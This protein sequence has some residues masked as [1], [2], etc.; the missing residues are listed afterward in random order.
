MSSE[1]RQ[2][3]PTLHRSSPNPLGYAT[4]DPRYIE[5]VADDALA[6]RHSDATREKCAT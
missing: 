1:V 3:Q 6:G 4:R 2:S 5:Q